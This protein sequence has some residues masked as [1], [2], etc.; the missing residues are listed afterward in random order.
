[1]NKGLKYG[2]GLIALY[3]VVKNG[4]NFATAMTGGAKGG[5]SL[6]AAFQGR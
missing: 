3:L 1:M 2:A 5:A 4:K 6:V